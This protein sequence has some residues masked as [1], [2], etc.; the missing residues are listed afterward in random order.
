M[1]MTETVSDEVILTR[2]NSDSCTTS[3]QTAIA[4]RTAAAS[5]SEAESRRIGD[6]ASTECCV[7]VRG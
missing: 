7:A 3:T 5:L 6:D 4:Q 2:Q 1:A